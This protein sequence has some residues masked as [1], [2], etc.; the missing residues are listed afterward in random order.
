MGIGIDRYC[1]VY[2]NTTYYRDYWADAVSPPP[3]NATNAKEFGC[4][5][6]EE[7]DESD[8]V[9]VT[10]TTYK[11]YHYF[12]KNHMSEYRSKKKD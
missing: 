2:D 9:W 11:T 7:M 6:V 4:Y 12:C 10:Y 8:R 5:I 1:H 3:E